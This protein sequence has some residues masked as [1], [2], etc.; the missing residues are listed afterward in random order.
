MDYSNIFYEYINQKYE[1][2]FLKILSSRL[3]NDNIEQVDYLI[4]E[5]GQKTP[6]IYEAYIKNNILKDRLSR[7]HIRV[8]S[9]FLSAYSSLRI[10]YKEKETL[11]EI[12]E[13]ISSKIFLKEMKFFLKLSFLFS[14]NK[15]IAIWNYFFFIQ[16]SFIKFFFQNYIKIEKDYKDK[17]IHIIL[18]PEIYVVFFEKHKSSFL[19]LSCIS[20]F[21][22][23]I[24]IIKN[25]YKELEV[26]KEEN[27]EDINISYLIYY[28]DK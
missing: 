5:I 11:L 3:R 18:K 9:L 20:Y 23:I 14:K 27:L 10:C 13:E 7:V 12:L 17:K 2:R 26:E 22:S 1:K 16:Q 15:L 24:E 6:L 19:S 25:Y 28:K 21:D 4:E 8:A